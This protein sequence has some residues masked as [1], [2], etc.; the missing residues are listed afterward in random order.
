MANV[1]RKGIPDRGDAN[2]EKN[3]SLDPDAQVLFQVRVGL[4]TSVFE[5]LRVEITK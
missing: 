2:G 1:K 3:V 5:V 4:M